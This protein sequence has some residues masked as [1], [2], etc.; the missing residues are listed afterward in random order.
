MDLKHASNSLALVRD[1]R[2]TLTRQTVNERHSLQ[3]TNTLLE[4]IEQTLKH[5]PT[6]HTPPEWDI[7]TAG[8]RFLS[9]QLACL[10]IA[11]TGDGDLLTERAKSDILIGKLR[12]LLSQHSLALPDHLDP[13]RQLL[14]ENDEFELNTLREMLSIIPLPT[15]YW[16]EGESAVLRREPQNGRDVAPSPMLRVIVFLDN[17]PIGSPQILTAKVL[18][19]LIFRIRGLNWPESATRLRVQL[20][21]TCPPSE[22]SV[23]PFVMEKPDCIDSGEYEADL[24]G[25]ISFNS[26]QSTILSDLVFPVHAAFE[27]SD[28]SFIETPL[29]GHNELRFRVLSGSGNTLMAGTQ[30]LDL[31]FIRVVDQTELRVAQ[32]RR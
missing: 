8:L 28:E 7:M 5:T 15:L 24:T 22:Y 26:G 21:T 16:Y 6:E 29:I 23:S 12:S 11:Q 14:L 25:N 9:N 17:A 19:S 2:T 18:Y 27:S 32:D 30:P 4:R 1:A 3:A 31:H 10:A 20:P 13:I